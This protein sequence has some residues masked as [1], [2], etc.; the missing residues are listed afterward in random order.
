MPFDGT[1]RPHIEALDKI[2]RVIEMLGKD[3]RWCKGRMYT[4]DGRRC[5]LGAI[6]ATDAQ[7][8]LKAP[9][10]AAIRQVT[11]R[12]FASIPRFNDDL[13]TTHAL[14]LQVLHRAR[15]DIETGAEGQQAV[16][17][18]WAKSLARRCRALV[19]A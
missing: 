2:D 17:A 16:A 15:A 9:V 3:E 12:R 5:L 4:D 1:H 19:A 8:M 18:G 7:A 11:G 14:V 10:L 13:A 6:K